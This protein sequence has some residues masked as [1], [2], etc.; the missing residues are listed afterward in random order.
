MSA[1]LMAARDN[2]G[3]DDEGGGS[4]GDETDPPTRP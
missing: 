3:G 2:Q 4:E 1:T